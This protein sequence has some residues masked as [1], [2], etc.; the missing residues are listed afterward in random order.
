VDSR[1]RLL[2]A[3]NHQ[4]P[5]RVPFDLGSTQVTGIHRTAYECWRKALQLPCTSTRLCDIVQQ[6]PFVEDD[7]VE[8]LSVDIRGL[9]P[10]CSHN[11][12]IDIHETAG[13][14]EF[15]DEWGITHQCPHSGGLYY[16]VV[17]H[18]LAAADLTPIEINRYSWPD[19]GAPERIA[20]LRQL[21]LSYMAQGKA[22]ALKGIMAGIF[23]MAQRLR[24][25]ENL[26]VDMAA[27]EELAEFLF[28]KLLQLKLDFWEMALPSLADVIDV[29]SE[30]DDYGTQISQIISPTMFRRQI[31]PRLR[32]LFERVRA[33]SPKAKI[34]FHS[35]GNIRPL[36]PDFLE[37]G[38]DILNP[39][40]INASGM[41]PIR[42]KHDF[43]K[44]IVFWGGGIDTQQVL[45]YG[46]PQKVR[47]EVHRNLDIFAPGGGFVFNTIHNIQADVPVQNLM[48]MWDALQEY[49][50][51]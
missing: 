1:M 40:H 16:S 42:L 22:V 26:L 8:K 45:P 13:G 33:L 14:L 15:I 48:A 41:D 51:Y 17:H 23:E 20:G 5:D 4:Q 25:T 32:R 44:E 38:I 6:L 31:K 37:L 49:G 34:F 10:R 30:A 3:L 24:G 2:S 35:C 43:G 28:D 12:K 9:F 21:A 18:P 39:V 46:T 47:D 19:A 50:K 29:V 7:F 11:W 27:N 36:L